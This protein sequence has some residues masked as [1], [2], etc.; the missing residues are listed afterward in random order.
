MK[1]R[2]KLA[3]VSEMPGTDSFMDIVTNVLGALFFV[4]IYAA[5]A[6]VGAEGT[7]DVPLTKSSN[8][9]GA[10]FECRGNTAFFPDFDT[11][12]AQARERLNKLLE[13]GKSDVAALEEEL[14]HAA[15]GNRF[16]RYEP[17]FYRDEFGV[18]R[19]QPVFRFQDGQRGETGPEIEVSTSAL[20]REFAKL[21]PAKQHVYFLVREDSF[22]VFRTARHVAIQMGL[23]VGWTPMINSEIVAFGNSLGTTNRNEID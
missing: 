17:N 9:I 7:V 11:G 16:Y 10:L 19:L 12:L 21:D 20:R 15:I 1:R 4:V 22:E 14:T 3:G 2:R 23:N 18:L 13:D 8:T 6:A 5:L